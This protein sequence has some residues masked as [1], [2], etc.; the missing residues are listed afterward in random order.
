MKYLY[1][2]AS[3]IKHVDQNNAVEY[4]YFWDQKNKDAACFSQWYP[5]S[6]QIDQI[7]YQSAEQYMMSQKATLFGDEGALQKILA[8]ESPREIKAIGRI[9]QNFD[10]KMW[11]QHRLSIVYNANLAKFS[12]NAELK[13]ILLATNQKI[14]VEASP[15]DFIWGVGLHETDPTIQ[16]PCKWKGLN[17]LGFTLMKV[18]DSI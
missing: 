2:I 5:I 6:F 12:Q 3:L 10:Q 1:D 13:K 14:L 4:F 7:V 17:L 11:E 9:I 8:S 18:R 15:V 16:D